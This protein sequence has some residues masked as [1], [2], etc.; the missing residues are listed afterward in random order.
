MFL[1]IQST[2]ATERE[3]LLEKI[4][5]VA[6]F[7][8]VNMDPSLSATVFIPIEGD[9]VKTMMMMMVKMVFLMKI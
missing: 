3:Q 9:G 2:V 1:L 8:N 5:T 6:H 7:A 4:K